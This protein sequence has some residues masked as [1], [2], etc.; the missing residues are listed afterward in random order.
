MFTTIKD[1]MK[2][3]PLPYMQRRAPTSELEWAVGLCVEPS[4]LGQRG[5]V[6]AQGDGEGQDP[7]HA[8]LLIAPE[9]SSS[10]FICGDCLLIS[11]WM[12]ILL[13][14]ASW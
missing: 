14:G 8:A 4:L 13:P 1:V 11:C 10:C 7:G 2:L 9:R 3:L 6:Q 5:A 12:A